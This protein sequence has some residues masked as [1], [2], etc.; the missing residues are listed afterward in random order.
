MRHTSEATG[1]Q[2]SYED[3]AYVILPSDA[4]S[5]EPADEPEPAGEP[6]TWNEMAQTQSKK[7]KDAAQS[8]K[9]IAGKQLDQKLSSGLWSA[10]SQQDVTATARRSRPSTARSYRPAAV[11]ESHR[12]QSA[13]P[14]ED[15]PLYPF[16]GR[17]QSA[18][19]SRG[20][21]K[22]PLADLS[23]LSAQ[24]AQ[25]KELAEAEER[26]VGKQHRSDET[27]CKDDKDNKDNNWIWPWQSQ[28]FVA[29][30]EGEDVAEQND[31]AEAHLTLPAKERV[32]KK[33]QQI[34]QEI[35][36]RS[37]E[38][39]SKLNETKVGKPKDTKPE[40]PP[41]VRPV[42]LKKQSTK[43]KRNA[44]YDREDKE[45][46]EKQAKE[47][48]FLAQRQ[49]EG[50]EA[51]KWS[52]NMLKVH[53]KL[54]K[55][56]AVI[57]NSIE[58]A[59][60]NELD[61]G[62]LGKLN[63]YLSKVPMFA[64]ISQM[65]RSNLAKAFEKKRYK[66][67]DDVI[68]RD[69]IGTE[70]YVIG[71]GELVVTL[72]DANVGTLGVGE[73][74]GEAGLVA[75][76]KRNATIR[77]EETAMC[78]VLSKAKFEKLGMKFKKG[79]NIKA[80][81]GGSRVGVEG[82]GVE[83]NTRRHLSLLCV[84][85]LMRYQ[86]VELDF[87]AVENRAKQSCALMDRMEKLT[88][89]LPSGVVDPNSLPPTRDTEVQTH[90]R[91]AWQGNHAIRDLKWDPCMQS[92]AVVDLALGV[93]PGQESYTV[94]DVETIIMDLLC[95]RITFALS[96]D[97]DQWL[98]LPKDRPRRNAKAKPKKRAT[99]KKEGS[100]YAFDPK[101][102]KIADE[103][104]PGCA[105][106]DWM[107]FKVSASRN[108]PVFGVPRF[109]DNLGF[110][111]AVH[112]DFVRRDI[113]DLLPTFLGSAII[114]RKHS[115]RV[116]MFLR[117][118]Q[119]GSDTIGIG[120]AHKLF[121]ALAF[122]TRDLSNARDK[123]KLIANI[124]D[125]DQ[126]KDLWKDLTTSQSSSVTIPV[127]NATEALRKAVPVVTKRQLKQFQNQSLKISAKLFEIR[128]VQKKK[129]EMKSDLSGSESA[130]KS[131][132]G[133]STSIARKSGKMLDFDVVLDCFTQTIQVVETQQI[134]SFMRWYGNYAKE[135]GLKEG[136]HDIGC[137]ADEV[138]PWVLEK[139]L[140]H[141]TGVRMGTVFY[142]LY[143]QAVRYTSPEDQLGTFDPMIFAQS[144][145]NIG[146]DLSRLVAA[147]KIL[148]VWNESKRRAKAGSGSPSARM[149]KR[150]T[151][152]GRKGRKSAAPRGTRKTKR[153]TR[154]QSTSESPSPSPSPRMTV[155]PR[156][157]PVVDER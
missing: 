50:E 33:Q 18:R 57:L 36:A 107:K 149:T 111:D 54:D 156:E 106:T 132:G 110:A 64:K 125:G 91:T 46:K 133:K 145:L 124:I 98:G 96:R 74:F 34:I 79:D 138:K 9:A 105:L 77:A 17:P 2:A 70:F 92:S 26:A 155:S 72:N 83:D 87:S 139:V 68:R 40:A 61:L 19:P 143:Q 55:I 142:Q 29:V 69:E 39:M 45:R 81:T 80:K 137:R 118:L 73:Y 16:A 127:T 128:T 131:E 8:T 150:R 25:A 134:Y 28:G 5:S 151:S 152:M 66:A 20:P 56:G 44:A 104:L 60:S 53:R 113:R 4:G 102:L 97:F 75:G 153:E 65:D 109:V 119:I 32:R 93:A 41:I 51:D 6:A 11:G 117:L 114:H 10:S 147:Y 35:E 37:L 38:K 23:A 116:Q 43:D 136:E 121:T 71:S 58:G 103:G 148:M 42:L 86:R 24:R 157:L 144:L 135:H 7:G 27:Q 84:R 122:L 59:S 22:G 94:K 31:S 141:L 62:D 13:R 126:I 154:G 78:F 100:D 90:R 12:P 89:Y 120:T 146:L 95:D 76:Q 123:A 130:S 1:S 52:E 112:A 15:I 108:M 85:T 115:L 48:E 82:G 129:F 99:N 140:S 63:E 101:Q 47:K 30:D 14:A 3:S 67:G 49:K 21:R 88:E